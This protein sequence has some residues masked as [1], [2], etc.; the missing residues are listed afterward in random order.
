MKHS[1]KYLTYI[2]PLPCLLVK[3]NLLPVTKVQVLYVPASENRRIS[4]KQ[5]D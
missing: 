5:S 4:V 1:D 2:L 3:T